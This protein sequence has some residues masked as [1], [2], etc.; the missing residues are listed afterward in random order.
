MLKFFFFFNLP[1]RWRPTL[2][3]TSHT[4]H[5][6]SPLTSTMSMAQTMWHPDASFG[7]MVCSFFFFFFFIT[8]PYHLSQTMWRDDNP[9]PKSHQPPAP[10]VSVTQRDNSSHSLTFTT[11][12]HLSPPAQTT[13]T[14][15]SFGTMVCSTRRQLTPP[16]PSILSP[17]HPFST[18]HCLFDHHHPTIHFDRHPTHFRTPMTVFNCRTR[19]RTPSHV[20]EPFSTITNLFDP[21]PRV[22]DHHHVF[23]TA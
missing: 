18:S 4:H 9:H 17:H 23:S 12:S 20:F 2:T 8:N 10:P 15:V 6:L 14:D 5:H 13:R 11:T 21:L 1:P 16:T 3:L 7:P 19:F 22:F